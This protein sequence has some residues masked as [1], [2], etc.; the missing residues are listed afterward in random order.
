MKTCKAELA[1]KIESTLAEGPLWHHHHQK[2]YWVDIEKM[3]FHTFDPLTNIHS[4]LYTKKRIGAV[5]P[6]KNGNLI[7]ALQGEIAELNSVTNEIKKLIDLEPGFPENRCNDGKCDRQG[8]LWIGTMQVDCKPGKGSLYCID[9][10]LKVTTVLQNLTIS[11]GI[12]WS[13]A[14]D[15]MYFIDSNDQHVK[16]FDFKV[17]HPSLTNEQIIIRSE[18]TNES[19]DGMC[20]DSEGM[21]WVAFWG[22]GRVGR[23]DP[24]TGKQLAEIE[25]PALHVTSCCFG[26]TDFQ[27]LYITTARQGL[28]E[29]QLREYPLSGSLFSC[30]PGIGG[31]PADFFLR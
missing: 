21:L 17:D 25:V 19:P 15:K 12:G 27:T 2:L 9:S 23:Y 7:L 4:Q 1:Y 13:L 10:N 31:L 20:T 24:A 30:Q 6:S 18:T 28:S 5:L 29:Q 11:N 14:G 16:Q 26:G 22:G 8:R 3:E